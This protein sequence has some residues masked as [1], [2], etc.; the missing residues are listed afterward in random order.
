MEK[1]IRFSPIGVVDDLI[2]DGHHRYL[3]S[4]LAQSRLDRIA[5]L[6][7]SAKEVL[8]WK[9]IE[10]VDEDWD[11]LAKIEMLN[12][13]DAERNNLTLDELKALIR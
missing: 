12:R 3:A 2:I 13:F 1:G 8:D 5:S 6:K 11:T 7:S 4:E 10:L 9:V